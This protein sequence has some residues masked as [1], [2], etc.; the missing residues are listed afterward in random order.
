M[1]NLLR[2]EQ[3][4]RKRS[5][6]QNK[7]G[8]PITSEIIKNWHHAHSSRPRKVLHNSHIRPIIANGEININ[9]SLDEINDTSS[10]KK[11]V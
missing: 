4:N 10:F 6:C 11:K 2:N 5:R 7:E 9:I 1:K 8:H 3:E